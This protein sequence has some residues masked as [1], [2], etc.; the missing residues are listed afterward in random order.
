MAARRVCGRGCFFVISGY[1]ITSI[2][3]K[4]CKADNF[5]LA[6]FYQRRIARICPAFFT[7]ALATLAGAWF[8]YSPQDL[9]FAGAKLAA[10]ALCVVNLAFML[11]QNYFQLTPDST[12]YLHY[13]SLSV[14]EQ[15]YIFFPLFFLLLFKHGRR[16]LV[17]WLGGLGVV[18]YVACILITQWKP[19][20]AFY[21][22]PTRAFELLAGCLLAVQASDSPAA[23]AAR[24]PPWLSAAG[25]GLVGLSFWLVH[26]GPQ[27]PGFWALLPVIGAVGVLVPPGRTAG[28][29]EKFLAAPPLVFVGRM[30]Y[31]LY[32]W[33]WPVFSLVDYQ[34]DLAPE[35]ARLGLKI[36][37][38]FLAATLS[39]RFIEKPARVS[40]NRPKNRMPAYALALCLLALCVPLGI[41]VRKANYVNASFR[42]VA[43]GGLVFESKNQT[44]SVVLLGD[45]NAS[46]YGKTLKE[47]CSELGRKLTVI[48]VYSGTPL[49]SHDVSDEQLWLDALAV[50]RR[51]KPD[52]LILAYRWES[53]LG[54]GS[55][56]ACFALAVKEL[57]PL[58]GHLIILNQPPLLPANANRASIRQGARP[59]FF[60]VKES[61]T[62]RLDANEY[63]KRFNGG[64]V[65]VVD[66]ASHFLSGNG[67]IL[68]FDGQGRQRFHDATHLSGY[69]ADLVRSE[70]KQAVSESTHVPIV[71]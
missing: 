46:M 1:L 51:E 33:H 43:H 53:K 57:K 3:F 13:W 61:Q 23:P 16:R 12:P 44:G 14:E 18:S 21:L 54:G 66:V 70:L 38:S 31:S 35:P 6:K 49:P 56:K 60:E 29:G 71:P 30:S 63:L 7:V 65:S 37:L 64:N 41:A 5:S 59:P 26:E 69:G 40:L 58:V 34:L 17:P 42:T 24:R 19:V 32:L 20:W 39:Y 47:I 25:L 10:A 48:S 4:E 8:I 36:G 15:F 62:I 67:E 55:G 50:V 45:S 22:L 28:L 52:C 27:F 68:F 11:D 9:A 2:I